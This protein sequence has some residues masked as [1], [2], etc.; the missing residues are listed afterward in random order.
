MASLSATNGKTEAHHVKEHAEAKGAPVHSFDPDAS[1]SEKAAVAGKSRDKLQSVIPKDDDYERVLPTITIEDV[2]GK[3]PVVSAANTSQVAESVQHDEAA[4]VPGALPTA[5]APA[6]PDWYRVGWRQMSGIDK[7]PLPEGEERDR[8]VLDMF[9]SEQFYGAWYHNGAIIIFAVLSSHFLTR[10]HFGWGWLFIVLAICNTYYSTSI[11]RVRRHARDDIQR[12]LVKTRLASEHESADWINNFLDRFWLIYEPVL[13]ATVVSSVDQILST[14][15]PPFLDSIRLTE[16][17]LGTKAPRIEKVR[18]FPKTDDDIVMMDWG[19]S[20]TPKDVSEMTQRQIKG[21]SNPRILLTIRLGA[22]V[23]TAAMPILVEDITLSGLLR[24]RMK[25]MSNFPHV[26]IVDLCFLEKPVIDYVLKPIGGETFGFDIANIP[27]LHSFIRDMTHATLGPMMYDPNIFTLNLEQLLSGKPLDAAIGVIQV[28]IHSARGIK[29]TKI[30]GGVPDPFVSLSISGRAELARTKYKANTYNPTWMETKFILINS[31]RDSLVF[32]VWDYNDHRKNTLLSSASFELAGLAEDAT[33]ENIVSH[34]LNDGKERGELKYDIS[35]YPVIEPEEGKEDLMNTTVGIVRLMIHQAKELDHTKSLSGELNP[36]AKV[37]LNGQS[38]SVF[39]TRLFKHT[40][41]PV[42]EAPYEFLC[43]D[44]ESSLVAVK[45]IDDRDFLKDP[46]VGFMSIKLTDLLESSGQA[47]RD[48][49]PLSGCKSGKL[50]VSAEWRPLTMAGSLHGSDQYKPPIGVVRLLLEKAVDVKNVEATLGGKSDPYVRVQVQ[51]TTK[52]RTEVINNN[53]NPVWD[54]IIYIPVYSL[55]ETLMLEC[56]DYQHLTRDRSL[57]SVELELSRLAAPYDDPRFPFQ[58]KGMITAVDPIRLDKGNATKGSLH[59]KA[60]F[61]PAL[62]IKG[63]KF[64]HA[65][66]NQTQT[67]TDD[68]EDGFVNDDRASSASDSDTLPDGPTIKSLKKLGQKEI[69]KETT[70]TPVTS[71]TSATSKVEDVAAKA[72]DTEEDGTVEMTTEELLAQQSGIIVF[73]VMSGTIVKKARLEVLLDDGYWPCFST[74]K[75]RSTNA[76]WDYVGEGFIKEIDFGRVWL[77]LNEAHEGEKD[78]IIAEWKGDAKPFLQATLASLIKYTL[79]DNEEG[80]TSTVTIETRYLPVPVTLEPRESVNNQGILRVDLIDGHDIHAVDRGGKSDPFA[81]FTLN[82]QKVFK[83]QTKKK[84]LSPEWNE[85]FEVSVPSRVAADFSVEIFDW[86]QI[87]AA[88]SLGVAKIEL[89]DIEPFQAAE[90]S[91]KLFLNKLGE[92]GQIRVRLVFQPEIIAKSRKNTSTFTS[93]GRAMTQIGGLPVD[94]GKGVLR[95]VAGVFK[96]G[97]RD[98]AETATIPD[99]HSGQASQPVGISDHLE[100]VS[101]PFPSTPP[102]EVAS[103]EPGT[104]R[105]TVLDAKD[106]NTGEI[107]PY[108][109]LRLGDKEYRTK[110]TSKTATP[111]WNETFTFA[112]SALTPKILLWVHDHKTLGKDKELSSGSVD[113]PRHIKM[114]SVSSADVFVELNH[115]QGGLLRLRLEFDP[116]TH[117]LSSGASFSFETG[118][119]TLSLASP[120]RFSMRSRRPGGEHDDS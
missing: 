86:N 88:K 83:S 55:R 54:Q 19:I 78:D 26:Q 120:S 95:G 70:V 3:K 46:V 13:S 113:I 103:N 48:W 107:K 15:T 71:P 25:L 33:R 23:A 42:W 74:T 34:L 9:L 119:R 28:T 73:N 12:E 36:L 39:T 51:N 89:S 24:I 84:T 61:I 41:N 96:R 6:I 109:V 47:G 20:F 99:V 60:S 68:E 59:Y 64:D 115:G 90:R 38:S 62:A 45:V 43:T 4:R 63:V 22:G 76:Q 1:P 106:F 40:N 14:N 29:G 31:L 7:P 102:N 97:D 21:K 110:H 52:G 69:S 56:M 35:Y 27:G 53:L 67:A 98:H 65:H 44:K 118:H 108:V 116:D 5:A 49:F 2:D 111:E 85:H 100:A 91:L 114:D 50:R 10:F 58:S 75:A 93:A 18:T 32:S 77:R 72:K 92:K 105:V 81:V 8:G 82:G 80:P 112:A 11:R 16:F 17:T 94:A 101:T 117:P 66:K 104:L 37:Y 87:E 30:G 79:L 57:G